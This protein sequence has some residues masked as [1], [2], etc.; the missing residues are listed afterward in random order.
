MPRPS[1]VLVVS[2]RSCALWDLAPARLIYVG[3]FLFDI[4]AASNA[5]MISVLYSQ[6]KNIDYE[7]QADVVLEHFDQPTACFFCK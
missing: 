2:S 5:G 1:P 4:Q 7:H 3:D 6:P